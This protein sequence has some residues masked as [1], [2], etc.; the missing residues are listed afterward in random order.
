MMEMRKFI[1]TLHDD[2]SISW[3]EYEESGDLIKQAERR[4]YER[5]VAIAEA[6]ADILK[7]RAVGDETARRLL[8]YGRFEGAKIVS[9]R[10]A[11]YM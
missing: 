1:V 4:G 3:N 6:A 10:L 8:S 7:K 9:D 11:Y 2:G 5:A